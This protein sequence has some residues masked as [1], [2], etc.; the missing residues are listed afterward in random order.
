MSPQQQIQWEKL[1]LVGMCNHM[2]GTLIYITK[3]LNLTSASLVSFY[4]HEMIKEIEKVQDC[5][6]KMQKKIDAEKK[7][8]EQEC[9]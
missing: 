6:M 4:L 5:K 7:A 3:K 8:R 1:Q 2:K 9:T